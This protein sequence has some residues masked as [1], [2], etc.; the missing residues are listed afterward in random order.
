[1]LNSVC[2]RPKVSSALFVHSTSLNAGVLPA[3]AQSFV[4]VD[5][6]LSAVKKLVNM[7]F[8]LS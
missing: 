7:G 2:Y 1:M 8:L 5:V 6:A 3:G 4:Q